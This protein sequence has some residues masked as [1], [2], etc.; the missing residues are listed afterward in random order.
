MRIMHNDHDGHASR[1]TSPGR[2]EPS[3]YLRRDCGG[4]ERHGGSFTAIAEP[5]RC[6]PSAAARTRII[7]G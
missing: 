3:N 6:Q 2:F 5:A 1:E 7:P 4:E